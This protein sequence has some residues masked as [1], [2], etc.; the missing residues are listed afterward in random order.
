MAT[1]SKE[2]DVLRLILENSPLKEWHFE[3]M[4]KA[5]KVTKGVANKWLGKYVKEGLLRHVRRRGRFPYFTAGANNPV[6]QSQK[7]VYALEKLHKSGLIQRLLSLNTAR[8]VIL[9][10]SIIRGDWYKDSDIDVFVFGNISGF[11]KSRYELKLGRHIELQVFDNKSEIKGVRT[12]LMKNII[13][14]Y[15]LKG[16]IQDVVEVS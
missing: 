1:L 14:G 10:G 5:A 7:R 13:N 9:F 8:T 12:G 6:Y 3:E 16:T 15:V 11:D 2:D 4:V